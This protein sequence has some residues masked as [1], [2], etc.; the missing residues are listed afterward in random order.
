MG[1]LVFEMMG[2]CTPFYSENQ[3]KIYENILYMQVKY[4]KTFGKNVK[5]LLDNLLNR[6]FTKRF[7]AL[8]IKNQRWFKNVNFI[9]LYRGEAAA[10]FIPRL[11]G[12]IDTQYFLNWKEELIPRSTQNVFEDVFEDF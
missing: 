9:G 1:I 2:G 3:M 12:P 11:N 10:P 8:A 7:G 6:D 5:D 4:P